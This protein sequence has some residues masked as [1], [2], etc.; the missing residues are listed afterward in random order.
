MHIKSILV[1]LLV[2]CCVC[3]SANRPDCQS[4]NR[5][6]LR[7]PN[8]IPR[9]ITFNDLCRNKTITTWFWR[10]LSH[11]DIQLISCQSKSTENYLN[12]CI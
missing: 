11:C 5:A 7:C 10:N 1:L 3:I 2:V 4:I 12:Y 6:C 8:K 9:A